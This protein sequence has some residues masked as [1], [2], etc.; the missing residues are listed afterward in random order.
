[1]RSDGKLVEQQYVH[2]GKRFIWSGTDKIV[3]K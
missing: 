1:M 2:A 3:T